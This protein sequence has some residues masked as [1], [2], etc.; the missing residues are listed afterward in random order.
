M[1]SGHDG[2]DYEI[3]V[4][5]LS[6]VEVT[7]LTDSPGA[8]GWPVW[9]PDGEWIAFTTERDDCLWAPPDQ[10]CWR[11][12]EPGE[13]HDVWVMRPNGSEQHRVTPESGHFVAWSPDGQH[14]LVSGRTLYV[15]RRD[16]SGLL[17]FWPDGVDLPPGGIP[18]WT[19]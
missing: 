12:D 4:V 19:E 9:S 16:G 6:S 15:V 8:D 3:Y 11:G 13:H 5:D 18:D 14:L 7:Q 2:G 1:F 17:E 10:D